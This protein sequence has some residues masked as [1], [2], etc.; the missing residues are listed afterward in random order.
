MRLMIDARVLL[1][2]AKT[3]WV[4]LQ[5]TRDL[6][7]VSVADDVNPHRLRPYPAAE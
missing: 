3:A 2:E 7:Y 6:A 5:R 4:R 1:P